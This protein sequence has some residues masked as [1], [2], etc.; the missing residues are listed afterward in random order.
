MTFKKRWLSAKVVSTDGYS[1]EPVDR[2]TIR[3][4]DQRLAVYVSAEK[5]APDKK[6]ILYPNDM[7]LSVP[8]GAQVEDEVLRLLIVKRIEAAFAFLGWT[9]EIA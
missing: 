7:R 3:Y 8:R 2:A 1:V 9:L 5:L 4:K 6:W